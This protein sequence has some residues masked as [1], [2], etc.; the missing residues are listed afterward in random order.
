MVALHLS[1]N[2]TKWFWLDDGRL[3]FRIIFMAR[4][5][6][7][8]SPY[9]LYP[10]VFCC[11]FFFAVLQLLLEFQP[12][13]LDHKWTLSQ[14]QRLFIPPSRK[15][16]SPVK[17]SL[18]VSRSMNATASW[19]LSSPTALTM[20]W[21]FLAS[22][23]AM[24]IPQKAQKSVSWWGVSPK[25]GEYN[26]KAWQNHSNSLC[27]ENFGGPQVWDIPMSANTWGW[28]SLWSFRSMH[29]EQAS[30]SGIK[31]SLTL[32]YHFALRYGSSNAPGI[33]HI[34]ICVL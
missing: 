21:T 10:L 15:R 19:R 27:L 32:C 14:H 31:S 24:T 23:G 5:L 13:F 4:D 30:W 22:S 33:H 11:R 25:L 20:P 18:F 29:K 12:A 9:S 34:Y 2:K 7:A 3:Y 1:M 6:N 26:G 16:T 28:S 17:N 8:F